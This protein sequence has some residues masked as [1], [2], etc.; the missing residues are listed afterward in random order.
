MPSKLP[1]ILASGCAALAICDAGTEL[2]ELIEQIHTGAIAS[3]DIDLLV[4]T[5]E[6]LL[7]ESSRQTRAQRQ[8]QAGNSSRL[9][10][11]WSVWLK[12]FWTKGIANLSLLHCP[13]AEAQF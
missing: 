8:E 7:N 12:P 13:V 6:R 1:N 3:W 10:S 4:K 5:L 11:A 9:S 2:G